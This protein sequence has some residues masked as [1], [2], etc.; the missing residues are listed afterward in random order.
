MDL[1]EC[2]FE[3]PMCRKMK[4]T[5]ATQ[6]KLDE[7]ENTNDNIQTIFPRPKFDP[8]YTEIFIS[9]TCNSCWGKLFKEE[10]KMFSADIHDSDEI[11]EVRANCE[12]MY[13]E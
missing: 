6:E 11:R 12:K 7:L 8:D 5:F 2:R 13:R 9:N 4:L 3:C 10:T 1:I